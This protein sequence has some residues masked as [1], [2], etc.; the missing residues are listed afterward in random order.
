[1]S[2]VACA[3]FKGKPADKRAQ[4][5]TYRMTLTGASFD[6]Q[7]LQAFERQA[8]FKIL[9][10]GP[11]RK[12]KQIDLKQAMVAIKRVDPHILEM[13]VRL[14]PGKMVRP[15]EVASAVFGLPEETLKRARIVKLA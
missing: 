2:I 7:K 8:E 13:T 3:P 15:Y 5:A 6:P 4:Q 11:K 10:S 14:E 1:V 12:T 9:R